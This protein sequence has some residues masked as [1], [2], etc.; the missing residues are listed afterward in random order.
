MHRLRKFKD[1]KLALKCSDTMESRHKVY[2]HN[3]RYVQCNNLSLVS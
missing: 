2:R 1:N 3:K